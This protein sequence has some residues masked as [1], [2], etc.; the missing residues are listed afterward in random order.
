[1]KSKSGRRSRYSRQ[2]RPEDWVTQQILGAFNRL[3]RL[4]PYWRR[5]RLA[6]PAAI[7]VARWLMGFWLFRP[8]THWRDQLPRA[9]GGLHTSGAFLASI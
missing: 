7:S 8:A 3:S 5:R 9:M 1:M 2:K 4:R 6:R